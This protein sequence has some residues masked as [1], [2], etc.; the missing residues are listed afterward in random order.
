MGL[1]RSSRVAHGSA[2]DAKEEPDTKRRAVARK[3]EKQPPL[4]L[5]EAER[6]TLQ[7]VLACSPIA[8][9]HAGLRENCSLQDLWMHTQHLVQAKHGAAA[10]LDVAVHSSLLLVQRL[11][12]E[13]AHKKHASGLDEDAMQET[14]S[15]A[16]HMQ[17]PMGD[18]FTNAVQLGTE[19]ARTLDTA[20]A[21]LVQVA[22]PLYSGATPS[23]GERVPC[24]ARVQESAPAPRLRLATFLSYGPSCA[25]FAPAYDTQGATLGA[26]E[27]GR[28]WET[29][30]AMQSLL[31]RRWGAR[32]AKRAAAVYST[33]DE[34]VPAPGEALHSLVDQASELDPS[35]DRALLEHSMHIL[36][37]DAALQENWASLASLQELQWLRT[38][39]DGVPVPRPVEEYEQALV[40]AVQTSLAKM[41]GDVMPRAVWN[42]PRNVP[43]LYQSIAALSTSLEHPSTPLSRGYAGTLPSG[44]HGA[45]ANTA[46]GTQA[47]T[48]GTLLK[49]RAIADRHTARWDP[50][51]TN[52][53]LA[54]GLATYISAPGDVVQSAYPAPAPAPVLG[55]HG[56]P[57]YPRQE[58]PL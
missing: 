31:R 20:H 30:H 49:P 53:A 55:P 52:G 15:F 57:L 8:S 43:M 54:R 11:L 35:L 16:L 56:V 50:H 33:L 18:Y 1:R 28:V 27:S 26:E 48:W 14:G 22:P 23:L 58:R 46:I 47:P 5:S 13:L 29:C 9:L 37:A 42:A 51:Q 12:L 6:S 10:R 40:A 17:L 4:F 3:S 45:K 41:L 24:G 44:T 38:R 25:S 19:D 39:L 36:D 21:E 2:D 7:S 34:Q 32:V